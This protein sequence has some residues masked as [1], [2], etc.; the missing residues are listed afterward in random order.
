MVGRKRK[1]AKM[2]LFDNKSHKSIR[3]LEERL[4]SEIQIGT[5]RFTMPAHVKRDR[6]AFAKWNEILE[7]FKSGPKTDIITSAD[8]DLLAQ[9]CL[10]YSKWI[11]HERCWKSAKSDKGRRGQT[12]AIR[13]IEQTLTKLG[14]LLYLNPPARARGV[15]KTKSEAADP[16]GDA[17]FGNV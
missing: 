1:S 6:Q 14:D 2:L 8:S 12:D 17:G 5:A 15:G 4:A 10:T 13:R 11:F 3:E 7:M 16:L 9:Y